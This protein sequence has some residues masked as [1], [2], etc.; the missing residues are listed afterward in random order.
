[1]GCSCSVCSSSD[2]S[3]AFCSSCGDEEESPD[4]SVVRAF[5]LVEPTVLL[6][7]S[8]CAECLPKIGMLTRTFLPSPRRGEQAEDIVVVDDDDTSTSL[9]FPRRSFRRRQPVVATFVLLSLRDPSELLR[10]LGS[11]L[12]WGLLLLLL[13][14]VLEAGAGTS[15]ALTMAFFFNSPAIVIGLGWKDTKKKTVFSTPPFSLSHTR[16]HSYYL[17]RKLQ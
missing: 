13:E 14:L 15:A 8:K 7:P 16:F 3:F 5:N 9:L 6:P 4:L 2:C 10:C 1:M 12:A 11:C 17:K